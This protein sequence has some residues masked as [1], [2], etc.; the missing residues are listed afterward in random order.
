MLDHTIDRLIRLGSRHIIIITSQDLQEPINSIVNQREDAKWVD[1]LC[2]PEGKNTA[3]AVGLALA[4]YGHAGEE[5]VLG[6]FP[7]D[8]HILDTNAFEDSVNRAIMAAQQGCVAT[9]GITPNRPET[10]YGYIEKTKWE[11]GS[12]DNVFQVGAFCEKPDLTT[13]QSYLNSGAHMWN[14]GIYVAKTRVL[15]EEFARHLP[16][17]YDHICKGLDGYISSYSLLPSISLDYG[18]AEKSTRMAVVPADFGWCDLGSWNALQELYQV[19]DG[20]NTCCGDDIII[21]DSHNC[22]VRQTN[23]SLVLYGVDNLLVVETDDVVFITDRDRA[24]DIRTVVDTLHQIDR[25]DLL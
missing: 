14:A 1:V 7:A 24:Q 11:V 23:K 10:G 4:K 19:D 25:A 18:I 22:V 9:L 15:L 3:P 12:L 16:E 20:H 8:H 17:I 2:E 6:I 13:A 5:E 21:L